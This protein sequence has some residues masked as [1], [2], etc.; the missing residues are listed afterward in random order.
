METRIS[1]VNNQADLERGYIIRRKVFIEEQQVPEEI[2]IDEY[3]NHADTRHVLCFD[4]KESAVATA[5]FRPFDKGIMKIERVAV[6]SEQRGKG[7]GRMM[8]EVIEEEAEKAK[9]C[10]ISLDAQLHARKFYER[11]GFEAS[12]DSFFEA[13]IEHIYMHK[14]L[15]SK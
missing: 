7:W 14:R 15:K 9:Y 10:W 13:G 5:R 4:F 3:D 11:L 8:M 1:V 12:G 2:E 6:L